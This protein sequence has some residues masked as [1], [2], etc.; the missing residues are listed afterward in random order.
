VPVADR[1]RLLRR[2]LARKL[3]AKAPDAVPAVR[4][5]G[6]ETDQAITQ[7]R[8]LARGLNPTEVHPETFPSALDDLARK[9]SE[10]FGVSCRFRRDGDGDATIADSS[11]ATH[12]YRIAQE[13]ISNALRHGKAKKVDLSLR[14]GRESLPLSIEDDGVGFASE[15]GPARP[16][17]ASE[18]I[19]LQTMAYRAKLINAVLDVRPGRR[20]GVVVTC[21]I[22]CGN[23]RK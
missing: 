11:A 13:A 19:G 16:R 4:K 9:V 20:R 12:L 3:R 5:L 23:R 15:A 7:V 6:E 14:N 22:P 21:S 17:E 8:T 1:R 2:D 10:T 18:G